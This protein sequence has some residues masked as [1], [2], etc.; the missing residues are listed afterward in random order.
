MVEGLRGEG[1]RGLAQ[2]GQR[3]DRKAMSGQHAMQHGSL[4]VRGVDEEEFGA[5]RHQLIPPDRTQ[6]VLRQW[7]HS[8]GF[9]QEPVAFH[10]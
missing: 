3:R 9:C 5:I 2:A 8:S 1:G 10:S 7:S 6:F 4:S